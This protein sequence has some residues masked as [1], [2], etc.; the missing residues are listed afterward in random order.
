[1]QPLAPMPRLRTSLSTE[2]V[3]RR[4]DA[5]ARKGRLPGLHLEGTSDTE[6]FEVREFGR[7]FESSLIAVRASRAGGGADGGADAPGDIEFRVKLRP[8]IPW[9]FAI[10]LIVSIWPGIYLVDSMLRHYFS[11]YSSIQTWWWYLPL[12]VPTSPWAIWS[13]VKKSRASAAAEA[14]AIIQKIGAEIGTHP[15]T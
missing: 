7:P 14:G 12:T 2:D 8:T 5:A 6:L 15:E 13:A 11:W 10:V 1:M 3:R 9:I 4:L